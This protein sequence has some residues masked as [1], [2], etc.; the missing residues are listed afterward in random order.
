MI[1]YQDILARLSA[2]G[3]SVYRL[4]KENLLSGSVLNRIRKQLPV[5]TTTLD[6]VCR[7]CG[8]QPGDLL[9]WVPD[10]EKTGE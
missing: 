4:Q 1:V 2:A 5:T 3:Y 10:S 9:A 7:L 6:V 8:C